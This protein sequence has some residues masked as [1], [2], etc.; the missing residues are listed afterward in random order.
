MSIL[1]VH[2]RAACPCEPEQEELQQI[3]KDRGYMDKSQGIRETRRFSNYMPGR[4]CKIINRIK[5]DG[6]GMTRLIVN[7]R[8][9]KKRL[10]A[11][12]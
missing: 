12:V 4:E 7:V 11:T 2:G 9:C 1:Y 8:I 10:E 5:E 6:R 3:W